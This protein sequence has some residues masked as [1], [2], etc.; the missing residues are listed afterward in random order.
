MNALQWVL[1]AAGVLLGRP[2]A[3]EPSTGWAYRPRHC[4]AAPL[5]SG[6]GG[7]RPSASARVAQRRCSR[8]Q[9][10]SLLRWLFAS[11]RASLRQMAAQVSPRTHG[12]ADSLRMCEAL[13]QLT[14]QSTGRCQRCSALHQVCRAESRP[15]AHVSC[16]RQSNRQQGQC[17]GLHMGPAAVEQSLEAARGMRWC[18]M[19]CRRL[20]GAGLPGQRPGSGPGRQGRPGGGPACGHRCAGQPGAF[21]IQTADISRPLLHCFTGEFSL[22]AMQPT[23]GARCFTCTGAALRYACEHTLDLGCSNAFA[24][25]PDTKHS[26]TACRQHRLPRG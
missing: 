9:T 18:R 26:L 10:A 8:R 3:P 11:A 5:T 19:P 13:P 15:Q 12:C 2:S 23:V 6:H 7:C 22:Q 17:H 4:R 20:R 25:R 1:T 24:C 14:P 21:I 16:D